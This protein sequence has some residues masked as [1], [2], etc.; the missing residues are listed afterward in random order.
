MGHITALNVHFLTPQ[1]NSYNASPLQVDVRWLMGLWAFFPKF[2]VAPCQM[3]VKDIIRTIQTQSESTGNFEL[4]PLLNCQTKLLVQLAELAHGFN[5]EEDVQFFRLDI[6]LLPVFEATIAKMLEPHGHK[7]KEKIS[8]AAV[9]RSLDVVSD[10]LHDYSA[11]LYDGDSNR[12]KLVAHSSAL[13]DC[14]RK[15]MEAGLNVENGTDHFFSFVYELERSYTELLLILKT[16]SQIG[17]RLFSL[18][19]KQS[20][21]R[22]QIAIAR[23]LAPTGADSAIREQRRG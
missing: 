3:A 14:V 23:S 1:E 19:A 13:S 8:T 6:R 10:C 11:M 21:A 4:L 7:A 22:L 2:P 9:K 20:L 18:Q 17:S 15:F 16:H 5:S 12:D